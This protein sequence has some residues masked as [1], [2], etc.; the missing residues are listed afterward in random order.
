MCNDIE[1]LRAVEK[2]WIRKMGNLNI[3]VDGRTKE[4]YYIDKKEHINKTKSENY[5]KNR[6]Q[7]LEQQKQYYELH[8]T[9]KKIL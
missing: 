1:E 8:K 2:S 7:R 6:E 9:T 4:E 5:Y 3:R